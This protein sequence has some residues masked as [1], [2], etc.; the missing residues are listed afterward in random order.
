MADTRNREPVIHVL[1][2]KEDL[3]PARI[4]DKTAIVVDVL[5][6][7][8]AII[9]AL[10]HGVSAVHPAR[11]PDEARALA[12]ASPG[13]P[14]SNP[15]VVSGEYMF[16][17]ID[18][19]VP[20]TPLA[21]A[22]HL[23]GCDTLIYTTTNGTV[24]LRACAAA[25]HVLVGS[26]INA[27]ATARAVG[28]TEPGTVVIVCAGTAGEFNMEDFYGAGCLV[29]RITARRDGYRM[30]DAA[31]A[32]RDYFRASDPGQVLH[33]SM[34]GRLMHEWGL[35]TEVDYAARIDVSDIIARLEADHVR[36]VG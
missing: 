27:D 31:L 4:A 16:E 13:R 14:G 9:T 5:F 8:T 3:D 29:D 1:L 22:R 11:D 25:K 36:V 7:T 18:G 19:F 35:E 12:R 32:A 15:P 24:A 2:R 30:T 10:D 17:F 34:V 26:L 21:L 23:D 20:P 28:E 6:A 33:G